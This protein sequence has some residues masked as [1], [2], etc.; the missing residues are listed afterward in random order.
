MTGVIRSEKYSAV[1]TT[2]AIHLKKLSSVRTAE[3]FNSQSQKGGCLAGRLGMFFLSPE[4]GSQSPEATR[5][6]QS[7]ALIAHGIQYT[8]RKI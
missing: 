2:A 1:Q 5:R 3:V 8:D 7:A 6:C 4:D